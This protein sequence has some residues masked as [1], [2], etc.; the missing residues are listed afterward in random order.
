MNLFDQGCDRI[1]EAM[2]AVGISSYSH[3]TNTFKKIVGIS[4]SE[5]IKQN[6]QMVKIPD[7]SQK[8]TY[9]YE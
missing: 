7:I 5:Y 8:K 6:Q 1:Q 2:V 3:F 9:G 4:P